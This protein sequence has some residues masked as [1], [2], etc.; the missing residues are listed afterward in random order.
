MN[1][2]R[3][4][5]TGDVE[6]YAAAVV[7]FLETSPASRNI[8]RWIIELARTG[9]GQWNAPPLF[10]WADDGSELVA[11]ASWTAPFYLTASAFP[12]AMVQPLVEAVHDAATAHAVAVYG[13]SGPRETVEAIAAA[14]TRLT[15]E[16][17]HEQMAETLYAL[18]HVRSVPKPPGARRAA[19]E[20]DIDLLAQWFVDFVTELHLPAGDDPLGAVRIMVA[21]GD[22]DVWVDGD[23]LVSMSGHRPPLAGVVRV[24]PVYTPPT[25]RGRGYARRLVAEVSAAALEAGARQCMLYADAANPVSNAIY[26]QIGYEPREERVDIVFGP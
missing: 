23:E 24:G 18:S 14:W 13:T 17:T 11:A 5:T 22:C 2:M 26:R 15:G 9:T 6:E 12:R 21:N 20:D 7:R 8:L 1:D 3:L 19:A 10:A 16:A 4:H 25:R